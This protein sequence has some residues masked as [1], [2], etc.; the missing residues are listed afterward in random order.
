MFLLLAVLSCGAYDASWRC[1]LRGIEFQ[2]NAYFEQL[3]TLSF[4]RV[5]YTLG[6][7]GEDWD[8]ICDLN[9]LQIR[10]IL[11]AEIKYPF[12]EG[13]SPSEFDLYMEENYLNR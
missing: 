1:S 7:Y 3:P 6:V 10:Q 13:Y 4:E 9:E 2:L 11:G 8:E 5:P 12:L